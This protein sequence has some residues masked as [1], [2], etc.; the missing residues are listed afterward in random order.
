MLGPQVCE[1]ERDGLWVLSREQRH[2]LAGIR[3]H[4]ELEGLDLNLAGEA[5]E[6]LGGLVLADGLL[7]QLAR[8]GDSALV[9]A[10]TPGARGL[11]LVQD[12]RDRLVVDV[13]EPRD[14]GGDLLD[15]FVIELVQDP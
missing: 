15:L 5:L 14:L 9:E 8:E 7:E 2:D 4:E 6:H 3:V 10:G 11:E 13:L 12:R 1:H